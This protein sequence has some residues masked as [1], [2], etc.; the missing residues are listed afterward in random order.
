M[1]QQLL[2]KNVLEKEN[3]QQLFQIDSRTFERDIAALRAYFSQRIGT[4]EGRTIEYDYQ[5]K[6]YYLSDKL[7]LNINSKQV[8]VLIKLLLGS[9]ALAV[10]ELDD[11]INAL[12][13]SLELDEQ[14]EIK[15]FISNERIHFTPLKHNHQLV[16]QIWDFS[17]AIEQSKQMRIEYKKANNEVKGY[18]VAPI[19]LVFSD[20]YFYAISYVTD[21][22]ISYPIS[23][24]MDRILSYEL[25]NEPFKIPYSQ[26]F[27][28]GDFSN[29][30]N[31][32]ILVIKSI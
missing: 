13:S 31:Q 27:E 8:L 4:L 28:S 14:R 29:K 3:I 9:R 7:A 25:Q 24:R 18:T 17:S 2:Q 21:R 32:V 30:I 20:F 12:C 5:Q 16:D 6:K 11:M 1:L 15:S 10:E 26:R 19:G 22:P 23:F